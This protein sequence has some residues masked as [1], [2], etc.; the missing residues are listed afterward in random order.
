AYMS[1]EQF[2]GGDVGPP[3]DQFSFF[4]VLY[5]LLYGRRP[6]EGSTAAE[7]AETVGGGRLQDPP[8]GVRGPG[9]LVRVVRRGL[10]PDPA[11]RFASMEDVIPAL[12]RVV[13]D[14]ARRRW[15]GGAG[16]VV[17]LGTLGGYATSEG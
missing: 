9:A 3:S 1:P 11:D 2:R 6:F 14:Q 15:V 7:L 10:R 5:E 13:R 16:V 17:L 4:V 12:D 8:A